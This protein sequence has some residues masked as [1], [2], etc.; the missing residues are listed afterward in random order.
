[1]LETKAEG[2]MSLKEYNYKQPDSSS[3]KEHETAIILSEY[4]ALR[5]EIAWLIKNENTYMSL[6]ITLFTAIIAFNKFFL[7]VNFE[8]AVIPVLLIIPIP[9]L[10][11]AALF[12]HQ[13][14][15]VHIVAS[16]ISNCLRPQV[17]KL[18]SDGAQIWQWEEW[19]SHISTKG[20]NSNFIDFAR[21]L[22]FLLPV[23]LSLAFVGCKVFVGQCPLQ[24]I[25]NVCST[26]GAFS[27]G[28]LFLFIVDFLG[29]CATVYRI[30]RQ[31]RQCQKIL[32]SRIDLSY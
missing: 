9:F 31:R 20:H 4:Q 23:A 8:F 11:F 32:N 13:H 30:R 21:I 15:E 14:I 28:L 6:S 19:K 1:M 7:D 18:C 27:W 26:Y 10:L 25:E 29:A 5:N 16:Y 2:P 3:T 22:V 12:Q 17:R 24:S